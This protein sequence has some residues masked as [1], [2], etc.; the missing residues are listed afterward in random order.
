MN[1]VDIHLVKR[2]MKIKNLGCKSIFL[3]TIWKGEVVMGF[4]DAASHRITQ[5]NCFR[6]L[7]FEEIEQLETIVT[8]YLAGKKI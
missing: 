1:I 4:F 5:I 3:T 8:E 7:S 2:K 6:T